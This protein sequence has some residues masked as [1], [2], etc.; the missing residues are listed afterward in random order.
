MSNKI[1]GLPPKS[2]V[3][4]PQGPSLLRDLTH[5]NEITDGLTTQYNKVVSSRNHP[6]SLQ[7]EDSSVLGVMLPD[8]FLMRLS[9]DLPVMRSGGDFVLANSLVEGDK[10]VAPIL[11]V[12]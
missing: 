7:L 1:H 4:T 2:I 12:S 9:N 10:L 8:G 6:V 5:E 3:F 11:T